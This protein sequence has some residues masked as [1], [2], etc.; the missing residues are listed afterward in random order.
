M[1]FDS[2]DGNVVQLP[3]YGVAVALDK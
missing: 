2:K 3:R 1:L